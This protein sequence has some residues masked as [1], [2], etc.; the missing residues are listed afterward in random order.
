MKNWS[1][2]FYFDEDFSWKSLEKA[3]TEIF[4]IV[5]GEKKLLPEEEQQIQVKYELNM[6]EINNN[7]KPIGF[8][9]DQTDLS[10]L[11]PLEVKEMI[12]ARLS[13]N[14]NIH[15]IGDRIS[16]VLKTKKIKFKMDYDKM[17]LIDVIKSRK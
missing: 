1:V 7:K 6:R 15:E 11:F 10:L 12:V 13:P 5:K 16:K 8:Y 4:D 9:S 2:H 14:E 17:I 3:F